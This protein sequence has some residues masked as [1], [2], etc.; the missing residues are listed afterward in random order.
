MARR[1]AQR[2]PGRRSGLRPADP[3]RVS[4]G[5]PVPLHLRTPA[6]L[7]APPPPRKW[8]WLPRTI[9]PTREGWWFVGATLVIGLAATNTGNNLLYLMVAMLLAFLAVSGLLS[10]Q[11][12]RRVRLEREMPER[13][14]AGTPAAFGAT[15]LNRKRWMTSFAL[16]L[17]EA[18][19][20]SGSGVHRFFLAIPPD[21][22]ETWL[23]TL[24]F[25]RRGLQYL[26]GLILSTR[27]P[28]GLFDKIA[29]PALIKPILVYP[30]VRTLPP[31]EVP[32]ALGLGSQERHRRG[33]G[34]G[35]YNLRP[36]R[37]GDDLRLVHWK[38]SARA[39][40]LVL[41]ELEDE[42]HPQVCV[43]MEDPPVDASADQV[44]ADLSYVASLAAHAIRG[45]AQIEVVTAEGTSGLG[46]G[47]RHLD[48]ILERLALYTIPRAPRP[49]DA[50][51]E[52][53]VR[54]R[55][56]RRGVA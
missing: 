16:H 42:E 23:Y 54:V 28:F 5:T 15:L 10:E 40:S 8:Y 55:L 53:E 6:A 14:Y 37:A 36:Y 49:I 38:T 11:S 29:R 12:L 48:R 51:G 30:A 47:E 33:R 4:H 52:R 35:L 20:A 31:A 22:S 45:G 44:E 26:P 13:V 24:T 56:G 2:S 9:R 50:G 19:P 32:A 7:G 41:K 39:G 34:A 25:P 46:A 21:G 17:K 3:S 1:G 18:N 27:Y 43:I